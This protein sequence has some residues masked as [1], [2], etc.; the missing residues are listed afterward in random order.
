M[1]QREVETLTDSLRQEEA[2]SREIGDEV[3]R[4]QQ[5]HLG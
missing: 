2:R 5:E 4:L 1:L 3:E